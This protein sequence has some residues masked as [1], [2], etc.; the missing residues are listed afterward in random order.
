[1]R[2]N[3]SREEVDEVICDPEL[4]HA[5]REHIESALEFEEPRL[6]SLLP[7]ILSPVPT[8]TEAGP[9]QRAVLMFAEGYG[10]G[11]VGE[12]R[13]ALGEVAEQLLRFRVVLFGEEAQVVG[14][15][16]CTVE[17]ALGVLGTSLVG[18]ALGQPERAGQERAL[19]RALATVAFEKAIVVKVLADSVRRAD[20]ALVTIVH[21]VHARKQ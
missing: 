14:R 20:H 2:R 8:V 9:L 15:G 17:D 16:E 11:D 19:L 1:M 10:G 7:G 18:Q 4:V 12:V 6:R 21:E 3:A 5:A 13:E